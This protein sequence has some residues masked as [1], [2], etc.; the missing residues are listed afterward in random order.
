M[1]AMTAFHH[2]ALLYAGQDEFLARSL[3]FIRHGTADRE[4]VLVA[5]GRDKID[6]LRHELGPDASAVRF[7]DTDTIGRNPATI[8]PVWSEFVDESVRSGRQC[9]G[10]GEPVCAD[11]RGAALVECGI[12]EALLNTAFE[13]GFG[14]QLMCPYDTETLSAAAVADACSTHP[15]VA[16]PGGSRP[17]ADYTSGVGGW[18]GHLEPLPAP[19]NPPR[20]LEFGGGSMHRLRLAVA[21]F[22]QR[23]GLGS[24]RVSDLVIA[25]NELV[26]N[27]VRHGGGE[28][29]LRLWREGDDLLC[30]VADHGSISDPLVGRRRPTPEQVGGRGLWIVN[31]LC[32]LVQVR[33]HAGHSAVRVHMS[34][35]H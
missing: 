15:Y 5:V 17:N 10:I 12:H 18:P 34:L 22:A 3:S 6:L 23:C 21:A 8:I 1:T 32:D 19:A 28:G 35:T 4:E 2:E 24:G 33:S 16:D 27:S 29:V 26:G 25:V 9:R 7:A 14:W 13:D 30:E 31:H 20:E 11:R